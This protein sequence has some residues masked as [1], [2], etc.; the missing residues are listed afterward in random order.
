M[1]L[2]LDCGD[3][4]FDYYL[5]H[6]A[7][8]DKVAVD[9]LSEAYN[10][11][12]EIPSHILEKT[13]A[14]IIMNSAGYLK[15]IREEIF[16]TS[17]N[18]LKRSPKKLKHIANLLE[19]VYFIDLV[20]PDDHFALMEDLQ[21]PSLQKTG[22]LFFDNLLTNSMAKF[23]IRCPNVLGFRKV[24]ENKKTVWAKIENSE[25]YLLVTTILHQKFLGKGAI[26]ENYFDLSQSRKS[27]FVKDLKNFKEY[28]N[29]NIHI[30][31]F[32]KRENNELRIFL[33]ELKMVFGKF[34]YHNCKERGNEI[35][36]AEHILM[37]DIEK[38]DEEGQRK[39]LSKISTDEYDNSLIIIIVENQIDVKDFPKANI[40]VE[41]SY[42]DTRAINELSLQIINEKIEKFDGVM[43]S[44]FNIVSNI[45]MDQERKDK[46]LKKINKFSI[47]DNLF[48]SEAVNFWY[49][50]DLLK[51][52]SAEEIKR[53][54]KEWEQIYYGI[55]SK[56]YYT[57][58]LDNSKT[59]WLIEKNGVQLLPINFNDYKGIK[60][61]VYLYKHYSDGSRIF[62]VKLEEVANNWGAIEQKKLSKV[63]FSTVASNKSNLLIKHPEFEPLREYM[64][65]GSKQSGC[66]FIKS[67][68]IVI[69]LGNFE[70]PAPI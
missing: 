18:R 59:F 40:R 1:L 36:L 25:Y 64:I 63:S 39:I 58:D 51:P 17:F 35:P 38:L 55:K 8:T 70:I 26:Q 57:I 68:D 52:K 45:D 42:T 41:F 2:L 27:G 7:L 48:N 16:H 11:L 53:T 31:K 4:I 60:Y 33:D 37:M 61:L 47:G 19:K 32:D 14:T 29:Y 65:I 30:I 5:K 6:E 23:L 69:E 24:N 15:E 22:I 3:Y 50:L 34:Y 20:T 62:Y 9:A 43:N 10:K 67:D 46:L 54:V 12:Y 44:Y 49:D 56:T 13:T 21:Q 66:Y 28:K